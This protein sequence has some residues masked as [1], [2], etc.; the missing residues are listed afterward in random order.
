MIPEIPEGAVLGI[1]DYTTIQN[2]FPE[3]YGV[4]VY[5]LNSNAST[6]EKGP[7]KAIESIFTFL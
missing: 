7:G 2:D 3:T 4:G 1:G 6:E 5:G